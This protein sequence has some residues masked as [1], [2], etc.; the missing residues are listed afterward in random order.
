M[1]L[2]VPVTIV[3]GTLGVGKTTLITS[4]LK[5]KQQSAS[6]EK[7]A[8]LVNEFGSLGI[9]GALLE[10]KALSTSQS[11]AGVVVKELA[12]GCLCCVLSAPMAAAVAQL[13]RTTKPDRLIVEPSGLGHPAGLVDMLGNEHLRSALDIKAIICLVDVR[14]I[15]SPAFLSHQTAQDQLNIADILVGTKTDLASEEQVDAF[16]A[17]AVEQYPPKAQV[18]LTSHG[19]VGLDLLD[20]PRQAVFQTLFRAP[21]QHQ[22]RQAPASQ[23]TSP[24]APAPGSQP[25]PSALDSQPTSPPAPGSVTSASVSTS[26]SA[27]V[28]NSTDNISRGAL[29]GPDD[30][31]DSSSVGMALSELRVGL[32]RRFVSGGGEGHVS[33]GWLF[34]GEEVFERHAVQLLCDMLLRSGAVVRLKGVFRVGSSA[35]AVNEVVAGSTSASLTEIAYKRESRV[36]MIVK[37]CKQPEQGC[38]LV[39]VSPT[40]TELHR[41][42]QQHD[43][44]RVERYICQNVT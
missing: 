15:T 30:T 44:E 2:P 26:S 42:V 5:E 32:P 17:Y 21:R 41:A 33:C 23:P 12:G 31:I 20:V 6:N 38:G 10:S 29:G 19:Q 11:G 36:E 13:V 7:W 9:D 22:V 24:P 43:W 28:P 4:L 37:R 16:R 1:K 27:A 14:S 18:V 8:I 25:G 35:V 3:T 39:N 34:S 40:E